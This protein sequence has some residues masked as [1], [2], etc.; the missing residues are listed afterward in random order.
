MKYA[1]DDYS[2][3]FLK[4]LAKTPRQRQG[5]LVKRFWAVIRKNGDLE[6]A[7]K[8]I[9]AVERLLVREAGGRWVEIEVARPLPRPLLG[10]LTRR[11]GRRDHIDSAE[12]QALIA[13]V[14]ITID[15]ERE[16][17]Y[18]LQRKLARMFTPLDP[19]R[20]GF[21]APS[22]TE[23]LT[24]PAGD[25]KGESSNQNKGLALQGEDL[26]GFASASH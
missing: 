26:T 8:I 21:Q 15:G 5:L 22:E 12:R 25:K 13:G 2:R 10:T 23:F 17:D 9:A 14:R 6:E 3:A 1:P 16:L 19:G 4:A 7:E 24:G 11:F 20:Y 18:S